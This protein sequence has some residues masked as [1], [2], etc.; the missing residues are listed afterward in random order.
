MFHLKRCIVG[1]KNMRVEINGYEVSLSAKHIWQDKAS[2]LA[3]LEFLNELSIV[4]SEAS[5]Y[6]KEH[7]YEATAKSYS[8]TSNS[9]YEVNSA[10]GLYEEG[11]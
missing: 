8:E 6:N 9:L 7:G 4:Y 3:S 10:H 11:K 1:G 2:K 5:S